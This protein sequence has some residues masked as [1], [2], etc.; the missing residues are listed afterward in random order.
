MTHP[1]CPGYPPPYDQLVAEFPGVDVY[2]AD[3]FRVEWG[4]IFHRGRLDGTARLLVIGQDPATE[5]DITRRILVG[6]AG[7]RTQGLLTRLG[8]TRSYVMINTFV[9]SVASQTGGSSHQHTAGIVDYRQRWLDTLTDH[10]SFDAVITLGTLAAD[11]YTAWTTATS[12]PVPPHHAALTHPTYPESASASRQIT[13]AA[14]TERL[15]ANWNAALPGLGAALTH[16][17]EPATLTPYGT[18]FR[19]TD[20]TPIPEADL[21]PGLPEWM[22]SPEPWSKRT[23]PNASD[24]RATL[25]VTV[26]ADLRP[27]I[28]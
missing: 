28:T 16:P 19:A 21:P 14:A 1:F 10:N 2:P 5:E 4:P 12:Q 15:L 11:A 27:W 7:Q 24:K 20:Y 8:I 13:L 26:P 3:A 17:D 22:R 23:G 18:A 25:T 9:Y 6:T